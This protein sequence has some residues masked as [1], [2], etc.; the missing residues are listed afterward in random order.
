MSMHVERM[1]GHCPSSSEPDSVMVSEGSGIVSAGK[2]CFCLTRAVLVIFINAPSPLT[3]G[4][5]NG[6]S[7]R[8]RTSPIRRW[9]FSPTRTTRA[10]RF[11][12]ACRVTLFHLLAVVFF[13]ISENNIEQQP[14]L[15]HGILSTSRSHSSYASRQFCWPSIMFLATSGGARVPVEMLTKSLSFGSKGRPVIFQKLHTELNISFITNDS[16]HVPV[17][18]AEVGHSASHNF[19][20]LLHVH[21]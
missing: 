20:D 5:G 4:K 9:R 19:S 12:R 6:P 21:L 2:I 11:L 18:V 3:S 13:R 10:N 1:S 7:V 15:R 14:L 8:E 16:K 17:W